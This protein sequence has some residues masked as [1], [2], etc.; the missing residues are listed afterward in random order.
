MAYTGFDSTWNEA[1]F[2]MMRIHDCQNFINHYKRNLLGREGN[3]FHYEHWFIELKNLFYEGNSKYT[4]K[5][6]EEVK[7][8]EKV[9]ELHLKYKPGHIQ[10]VEGTMGENK[11]TFKINKENYD[12]IIKLLEEYEYKIKY[13]N[14]KHGLST[15]NKD[16]AGYFR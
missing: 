3:K 10:I 9:I 16:Q 11:T 4:S 5:E 8:I 2:K 7:Q 15:G 1:M 14:D 13:Y 6:F 12:T